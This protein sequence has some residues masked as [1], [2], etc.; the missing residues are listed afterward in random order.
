MEGLQPLVGIPFCLLFA[1]SAGCL[2]LR[3]RRSRGLERQQIK[4]VVYAACVTT[5][6]FIVSIASES[7]IE[8]EAFWLGMVGLGGMPV[9]AGVAILRYRLYEIDRVINRTLVYAL[10]TAC[11]V[12]VYVGAVLVLQALLAPSHGQRRIE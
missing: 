7:A 11:L 2:V 4:W 5:S 3:L 1:A 6:A 8:Q 12:G 9:A 10:L